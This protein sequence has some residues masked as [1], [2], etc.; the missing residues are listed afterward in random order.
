MG[1]AGEVRGRSAVVGMD[2]C[3]Y[4]SGIAVKRT[5]YNKIR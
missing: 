2:V 3:I 1:V 4:N 5:S